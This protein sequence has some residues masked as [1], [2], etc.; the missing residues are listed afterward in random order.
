VLSFILVSRKLPCREQAPLPVV[1]PCGQHVTMISIG[2]L[3]DDYT[4]WPSG[5]SDRYNCRRGTANDHQNAAE[6]HTLSR[7]F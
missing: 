3:D 4:P 7:M 2:M 6:S 5:R 1:V